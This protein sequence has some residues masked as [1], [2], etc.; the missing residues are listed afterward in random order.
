MEVA[1]IVYQPILET[2]VK[3][4]GVD[5]QEAC[6]MIALTSTEQECRLGPLRNVI[7]KR[8]YKKLA[9]KTSGNFHPS[10]RD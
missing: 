2:D 3:F 7:P 1:Q 4:V 5:Y 10:G 8:R 6:R 9:V